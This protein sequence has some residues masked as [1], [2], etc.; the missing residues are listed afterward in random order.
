MDVISLVTDVWVALL[1]WALGFFIVFSILAKYFACNPGQPL[2]RDDGT[3]DLV[4]FFVMPILN[5]YIE[6]LILIT[7]MSLI[8]HGESQE[9]L[10]HYMN[11]GFGPLSTLP[12]WVQATSVFIISDF[13]LY[14]THRWFHSKKMWRFHAIHHSTL[15]VD[16]LSTYRFHPIN[17]W[18]SFTL[19]DASMLLVGFSPLAIASMASVNMIYS[20]LVHAN[21]NWTF[22]PFKYVFVSPVFHRWH[23][24]SQQE[25]M[26]KNFAPTF[27]L[28]DVMFG[29]FYMPEGK[30]PESYGVPGSNIPKDFTGQML[31]PFK[32]RHSASVPVDGS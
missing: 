6:V 17:T 11:D 15:H 21:L 14:W 29:T 7:G 8:F 31:W 3:T 16:W 19:V 27:P 25:G 1:P 5:R 26:D 18:L 10:Q 28:I 2:W 23:H 32:Q 22:G 20:A 13:M 4:Y 12:I 24:T 9:S 30:L